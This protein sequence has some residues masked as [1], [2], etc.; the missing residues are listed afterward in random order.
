[1]VRHSDVAVLCEQRGKPRKAGSSDRLP[2]WVPFCTL[3]HI[4]LQGIKASCQSSAVLHA[5]Q[6]EHINKIDFCIMQT[7]FFYLPKRRS[8]KTAPQLC[9]PFGL[10]CASH[11]C[12]DGKKNSASPQAV[13]PSFPG[14]SCDAQLHRMG[15]NLKFLL[16]CH[17]KKIT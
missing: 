1:M 13:L 4:I 14:N 17:S 16:L 5:D 9:R 6:K 11:W 3:K 12:R 7:F 10:P 2:F 15:F 8:K